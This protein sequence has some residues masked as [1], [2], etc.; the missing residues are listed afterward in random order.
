MLNKS[1]LAT[2]AFFSQTLIAS[3]TE[4]VCKL[5]GEVVACGELAGA[6][7]GF[8]IFAMLIPIFFGVISILC[9]IFWVMMLVHAVK[10][11]IE[12]KPLWI[13]I[14]LLGN[15]I[16]AIV[17]YFVVKKHF[18]SMPITVVNSGPTVPPVVPPAV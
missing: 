13:I 18:V 4:A 17:Y 9:L 3:A 12:N 16:G 8:A 1:L 10:N 5:N 6:A 14:I 15:G 11:P 2:I 7:K